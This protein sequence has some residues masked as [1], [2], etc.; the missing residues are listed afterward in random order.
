MTQGPDLTNPTVTQRRVAYDTDNMPTQVWAPQS[1]VTTYFS[2]DGDGDR[3]K[4]T[5]TGGATVYY[6][7][8]KG[9][10]LLLTLAMNRAVEEII[11]L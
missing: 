6:V 10:S 9:S 5:T 7:R 4:K 1:G 8:K 2:Y 11:F 3:V